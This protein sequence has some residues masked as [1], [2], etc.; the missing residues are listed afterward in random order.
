MRNLLSANFARLW[1]SR[2]FWVIGIA[3][4]VWGVIVY[5]LAAVNTHDFGQ[6]WGLARANA[7]FFIEMLYMGPALAVFCG[8]YIGLEHSDGTIRNKLCV[9]HSRRDIYLANLIVSVAVGLMILLTHFLCA[10]TIG[11]IF[12][13]PETFLG[14]YR[15]FWGIVCCICVTLGYTAIFSL[16]A[17]LDTN[18]S[19]ALVFSIFLSF[20]LLLV[21]A[22]V[23]SHIHALEI[24]RQ[25]LLADPDAFENT[26]ERI[27]RL[28]KIKILLQGLEMLLPPAQTMYLINPEGSC[29]A[30]LPLCSLGLTVVLTSVGIYFF[31]RKDIK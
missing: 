21:G 14:L 31:Q 30:Y 13:G 24:T 25:T 5:A 8:F 12:A 20:A 7:N 16:I 3:A 23:F 2:Y 11:L 28:E 27:L 10:C 6:A 26:A 17:M 19:R 4:A 22:I 15:P 1:K 9:G 29:P 18:K